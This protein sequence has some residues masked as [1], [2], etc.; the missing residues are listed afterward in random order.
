MTDIQ[1]RIMT[2]TQATIRDDEDIDEIHISFVW[3]L[4]RGTKGASPF[5]C[6]RVLLKYMADHF[7][8]WAEYWMKSGSTLG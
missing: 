3:K 7:P 6:E 2:S 1:N 4:G 8:S 5:A